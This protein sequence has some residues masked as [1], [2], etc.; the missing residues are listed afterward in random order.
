MSKLPSP[1]DACR[2][3]LF[4][5]EDELREKYPVALAERVLRLR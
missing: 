3:D 1:I 4:T 2:L 5:A